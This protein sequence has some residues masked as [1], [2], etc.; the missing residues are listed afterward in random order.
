ML[1]Q[2]RN[3]RIST[4]NTKKFSPLQLRRDTQINA[5]RQNTCTQ[6]TQ[7]DLWTDGKICCTGHLIR[8]FFSASI[9]GGACRCLVTHTGN[10][11]K[12]KKSE[13][14]GTLADT[15]AEATTK[16][17]HNNDTSGGQYITVAAGPAA[18]NRWNYLRR[19]L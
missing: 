19:D 11:A 1:K 3:D 8:F 17:Q 9:F 14:F 13:I 12:S 7:S 15:S 18:K 4:A 16:A 2:H 5:W 10:S 6:K